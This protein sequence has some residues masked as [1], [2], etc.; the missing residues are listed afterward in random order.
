MDVAKFGLPVWMRR[1]SRRRF[2]GT[3]AGMLAADA[4]LGR[5]LL[6]QIAAPPAP[7]DPQPIPGGSPLGGGFHF[8]GPGFPDFDP[9]DAEPSTITDFNGT[10][11]LAYISGTV[12]RTT[13]STGVSVDLP[14]FG[15]DMRFMDGVY[16]GVDGR[17][18][19]GTFALI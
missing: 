2:V 14:F 18:R 1:L 12:R 17:V 19:Q 15:N 13:I 11:G 4:I 5:G 10:V 3:A 7:A 6:A 9:A 8:F 16:R